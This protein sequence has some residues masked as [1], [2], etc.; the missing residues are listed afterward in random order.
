MKIGSQVTHLLMIVILTFL[1]NTHSQT[2]EKEQIQNAG[3]IIG[4]EFTDAER[5]SMLG[6]LDEQ[7]GNY[8]K[9]REF[10]LNNSIPPAILFNPIPVGFDLPQERKLLR[11]SD[12][13]YAKLPRDKDELAFYSIGELA[14]LI[15]TKQTTSTELTEYFIKRL[16]KYDP[17]LHCVITITKERAL[18]HAKL[19]DEEIAAGK[20]RG[21]LHGIPFGAKDLLATKDY[22]TTWGSVPFKEQFI[23]EDATIIKKLEDAGAVLVA[24]L[25]MFLPD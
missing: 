9:I 3:K 15:R 16:E 13:S 10:H 20:Y 6:F 1:Q 8:K 12:Y 19:M 22:K 14:E 18:K 17:V 11:F 21:L 5:D 2:I 23:D 4:L 7:L 24:K 25:T